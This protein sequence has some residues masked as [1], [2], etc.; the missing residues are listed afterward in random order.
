VSLKTRLLPRYHA[1]VQDVH[2]PN[3]S[4]NHLK[5]ES[6]VSSTATPASSRSDDEGALIHKIGGD[7]KIQSKDALAQDD[8]SR[9]SYWVRVMELERERGHDK[10]KTKAPVL[11]SELLTGTCTEVGCASMRY[12]LEI[13]GITGHVHQ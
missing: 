7:L 2:L 9:Y 6:E 10:G 11:G 1:I 12:V 5:L 3:N 8:P 13:N 4:I